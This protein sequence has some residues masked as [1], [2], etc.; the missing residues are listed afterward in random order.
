M[1]PARA[2]CGSAQISTAWSTTTSSGLGEMTPDLH[3][4][5]LSGRALR[6]RVTDTVEALVLGPALA[7]SWRWWSPV[8]DPLGARR[9]AYVGDLPL[10]RAPVGAPQLSQW[11]ARWLDAVGLERG[12]LA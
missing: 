6:Y 9:C 1:F 4:V 2:S 7:G 8:L 11:L 3:E 12:E 5:G 10:L